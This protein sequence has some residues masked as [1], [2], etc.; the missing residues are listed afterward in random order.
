M[1]SVTSVD[2]VARDAALSLLSCPHCGAGLEWTAERQ[3]GCRAGHR[4]DV[5]RQGYLPLLGARARTDTGDDAAMVAARTAFLGAGHY[6]PIA[7]AVAARA[8]GIVLEIG[9]GTGHYL[10][11]TDP[12]LGIAL[13]SSR[14]AARRAASVHP[15]VLSVLADAWSPWPVRNDAVDTVLVV[16]APRT[17]TEIARVLRPGGLAVVVT[18][19]P[20]HLAEI[21]GVLGMLDVG[22]GKAEQ[23][24][25]TWQPMLA[26]IDAQPV[27]QTLDLDHDD[28]RALVAMGPTA[29]H[30]TAEQIVADVG[31][32]PPRVNVTMAVTVTVLRA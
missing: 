4:F 27:T 22:A 1:T 29:R 3:V 7:D 25:A 10:A 28:L 23:V 8:T 32:L 15:R 26:V 18:P 6:R 17:P 2:T 14:F 11:A 5:A 30:R 13:D 19:L 12:E 24:R 31:A 21:R 20:A 9:A 16:F